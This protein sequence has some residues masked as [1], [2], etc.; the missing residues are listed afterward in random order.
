[1]IRIT[2]TLTGKAKDGNITPGEIFLSDQLGEFDH[3]HGARYYSPAHVEMRF[4]ELVE[5]HEM[6]H[7]GLAVNNFTDG[8]TKLCSAILEY[9]KGELR[10][11]DKRRLER[12]LNKVHRACTFTH[13][14]TA[15]YYTFLLFAYKYPERATE[16][17][18]DLS[19]SYENML[20][21]GERAFGPVTDSR[22]IERAI[23]I[24][25]VV[26]WIAIAALNLEYDLDLF[27]LSSLKRCG[28]FVEA[29]SPDRRYRRILESLRPHW[30]STGLISDLVSAWDG[31][32]PEKFQA[33]VYERLRLKHPEVVFQATSERPAYMREVF[34][35]LEGDAAERRY[36]FFELL[37][38]MVRSPDAEK[39]TPFYGASALLPGLPIGATPDYTINCLEYTWVTPT[40]IPETMKIMRGNGT[41]VA[42]LVLRGAPPSP[43]HTA[44]V[45]GYITRAEGGLLG[46]PFQL[47][48][49]VNQLVKLLKNELPGELI[50][51]LDER[52]STLRKRLA[53]TG[54]W[55]IVLLAVTAFGHILETMR[56][57]AE[58]GPVEVF[59]MDLIPERG[60]VAVIIKPKSRRLCYAAP[61]TKLGRNAVCE[62]IG[63]SERIELQELNG[64]SSFGPLA[65]AIFKVISHCYL[66][67]L[68]D[69][70]VLDLKDKADFERRQ[71]KTP[72]ASLDSS[73]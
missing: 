35:V 54:H 25:W 33:K 39:V 46:P 13:E 65:P 19:G 38:K 49:G 12:F 16:A 71:A 15:N 6:V 24:L 18:Q 21:A 69:Y 11:W 42:L 37:R 5:M 66:G 17:R 61:V 62:E 67:L 53:S 43:E 70:R 68:Q 55:V 32:G 10:F 45:L 44:F 2:G 40:A 41:A 23:K 14:V 73:L 58:A 27:R 22:T 48:V 3:V 47:T 31:A 56:D 28:R 52:D 20:A 60:Y 72:P 1:M 29:N 59:L 4:P 26:P 36:R 64:P 50:V 34:Q 8:V 57:V 30:D 63:K 7:Q 9:G 51:K